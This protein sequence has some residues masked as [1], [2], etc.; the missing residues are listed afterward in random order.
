MFTLQKMNLISFLLSVDKDKSCSVPHLSPIIFTSHSDLPTLNSQP[1]RVEAVPSTAD[2]DRPRTSSDSFNSRPRVASWSQLMRPRSSSHDHKQKTAVFNMGK[3]SSSKES[4]QSA[5]SDYIDMHMRPKDKAA[6]SY[7]EMNVADPHHTR[8]RSGSHIHSKSNRKGSFGSSHKH[9]N[10]GKGAKNSSLENSQSSGMDFAEMNRDELHP[11]A[12]SA[13]LLKYNTRRMSQ[14]HKMSEPFPELSASSE[15]ELSMRSGASSFSSSKSTSSSRSSLARGDD[16]RR[17]ASYKPPPPSQ[18]PS[19][20][21]TRLDTESYVDCQQNP[22]YRVPSQLGALST[23][24]LVKPERAT[25]FISEE[26]SSTDTAPAAR[27]G[28]VGSDDYALMMSPFER[29]SSKSSLVSS[30]SRASN[31]AMSEHPSDPYLEMSSSA[32]ASLPRPTKSEDPAKSAS[33]S[34]GKLETPA[35]LVDPYME[36]DVVVGNNPQ[37]SMSDPKCSAQEDPYLDMVSAQ[38]VTPS[39]TPA[40][41]YLLMS[42]ASTSM[43]V[44]PERKPNAE[45]KPH[46]AAA[47]AKLAI[48]RTPSQATKLAFNDVYLDMEPQKNTQTKV[49]VVVDKPKPVPPVDIQSTTPAASGT[50]KKPATTGRSKSPVS[51]I[52]F[53]DPYMVMAPEIQKN[54]L[55]QLPVRPLPDISSVLTASDSDTMTERQS[56]ASSEVTVQTADSSGDSNNT[57]VEDTYPSIMSNSRKKDPLHKQH[58]PQQPKHSSSSHNKVSLL[59]DIIPM[60]SMTSISATFHRS[61]CSCRFRHQYAM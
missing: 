53:D 11:T 22:S 15:E 4:V 42:S 43:D 37:P 21:D 47:N 1:P 29:R 30:A 3:S 49:S 8:S 41:D 60:L 14:P 18:H 25:S 34:T 26:P 32:S 48:G 55:P 46:K 16:G 6:S 9:K 2:F 23:S 36:M 54:S 61:H 35:N 17:V 5:S 57:M 50:R 28:L 27:N 40:V 7:V 38:H 44:P 59:T 45:V 33:Q 12:N 10:F 19:V 39:P 13:A 56:N 52:Q 51:P 24:K 20:L 31:A 58:V